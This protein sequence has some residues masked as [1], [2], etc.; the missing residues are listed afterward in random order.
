MDHL[1][2]LEPEQQAGLPAEVAAEA[3]VEH[4]V[5]RDAAQFL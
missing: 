2:F 3:A 1:A 4:E 5:R